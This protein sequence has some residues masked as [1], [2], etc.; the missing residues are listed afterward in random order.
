M[1]IENNNMV[2]RLRYLSRDLSK[3]E[4]AVM[5]ALL[6]CC[7]NIGKNSHFFV[8]ARYLSYATASLINFLLSI[9]PSLSLSLSLFHKIEKGDEKEMSAS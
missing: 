3:K 9:L 4:M 7:E 1:R 2:R 5:A 6:L 8:S